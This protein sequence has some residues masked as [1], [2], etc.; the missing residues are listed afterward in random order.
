MFRFFMQR[1]RFR[2]EC[3]SACL[4]LQGNY[5]DVASLGSLAVVRVSPTGSLSGPTQIISIPGTG[6]VA[7]R[8][9]GPHV[10]CTVWLKHRFQFHRWSRCLPFLAGV[11]SHKY[12]TCLCCRPWCGC[13][14][15]VR[16]FRFVIVLVL[17][18]VKIAQ[19]FVRLH[20]R[21][22]ETERDTVSP[23]W[24]RAASLGYCVCFSE[25]GCVRASVQGLS[26]LV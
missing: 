2:L 12:C 18:I 6:P 15:R 22:P 13:R 1:T 23:S 21:H 24:Q 20:R 17:L 19:V 25:V 11:P 16:R 9:A 3:R 8:Q 5:S 10:H 7:A 4:F 14:S 26:P